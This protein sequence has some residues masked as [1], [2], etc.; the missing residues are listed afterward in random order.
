VDLLW[1]FCAQKLTVRYQPTGIV[2]HDHRY[3][4]GEFV[5]RRAFYAGSEPILLRRHPNNVRPLTLPLGLVLAVTWGMLA[6]ITKLWLLLPAMLLPVLVELGLTW[7]GWLT[8]GVPIRRRV[9]VRATV[10]RY[11]SAA[12]FSA[13]NLVRYYAAPLVLLSLLGGVAWTP[14]RW[15]VLLIAACFVAVAAADWWRLRPRLNLAAF[16]AG[17]V[18]DT[19]A[20]HVGLL[21]ACVQQRTFRPLQMKI[22]LVT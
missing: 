13:A 6:T 20:Y 2:F 12:Y 15:L 8:T 19:V 11:L 3:R 4:L 9:M 7:R 14:A 1:R 5:S 22:R 18:L 17:H 21:V 10:N 16:A